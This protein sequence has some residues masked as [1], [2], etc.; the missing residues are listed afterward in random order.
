MLFLWQQLQLYIGVTVGKIDVKIVYSN[1]QTYFWYTCQLEYVIAKNP[2]PL[3]G[4]LKLKVGNLMSSG[5]GL[6]QRWANN[7]VSKYIQIV[8]KHHSLASGNSCIT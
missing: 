1:S 6:V 3:N 5:P 7:S 4:G 2:T 8:E